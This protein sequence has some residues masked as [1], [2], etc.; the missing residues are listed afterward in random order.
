[1][2]RLRASSM[3]PNMKH[4]FARIELCSYIGKPCNAYK[5]NSLQ[6]VAYQRFSF[7]Q[8]CCVSTVVGSLARLT[9]T[10]QIVESCCVSTEITVAAKSS[11]LLSALP[12]SAALVLNTRFDRPPT[13]VYVQLRGVHTS[14]VLFNT[15]AG[16]ESL[17]WCVFRRCV[18]RCSGACF[19]YENRCSIA[20]F[21][22]LGMC[23]RGVFRAVCAAR[24]RART[25]CWAD[26]HC[27]THRLTVV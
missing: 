21:V 13:S 3:L 16:R 19:D 5:A 18:S 11:S 8:M 9:R 15:S 23:R 1:M 22:A 6:P 20:C 12:C 17:Q 26:A 24:G 27:E 4:C 14:I 25:R 7:I 2:I 10:C